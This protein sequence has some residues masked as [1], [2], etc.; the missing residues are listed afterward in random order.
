MKNIAPRQAPLIEL[1]MPAA[2]GPNIVDLAS[3]RSVVD[4]RFPDVDDILDRLTMCTKDAA[5]KVASSK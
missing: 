5:H 1:D 4:A 3:F 2:P